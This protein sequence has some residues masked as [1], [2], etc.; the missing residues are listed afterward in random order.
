MHSATMQ[1][2]PTTIHLAHY[3]ATWIP[4]AWRSPAD[5]EFLCPNCLD[6]IDLRFEDPDLMGSILNPPGRKLNEAELVLASTAN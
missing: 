4:M 1:L 5:R 2:S 3:T 6:V